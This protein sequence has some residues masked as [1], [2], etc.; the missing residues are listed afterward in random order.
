M[1]RLL[2]R[3]AIVA[4]SL[5]LPL[6]AGAQQGVDDP[7][8][9]LAAPRGTERGPPMR[10]LEPR[11]MDPREA[12]ERAMERQAQGDPRRSLSE[13]VR[14]VQRR[15]GGQILGAELVPFEGRNISRIKY[16]D[17]RGRVRYMD[18]PGP[19]ERLRHVP[20]VPRRDDNDEP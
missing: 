8:A 6:V 7:G 19:G 2:R 1:S 14:R 15:T 16:M 13:A 3:F 4:L 10:G 20:A 12:R 17:D 5:A 9:R 18:D 11:A